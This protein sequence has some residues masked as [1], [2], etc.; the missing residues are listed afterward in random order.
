MN[1]LETQLVQNSSLL[2]PQEILPEEQLLEEMESYEQIARDV[3]EFYNRHPSQVYTS[4]PCIRFSINFNIALKDVKKIEAGG[5]PVILKYLAMRTS[6]YFRN[7]KRF[8]DMFVSVDLDEGSY[9]FRDGK[10]YESLIK[11]RY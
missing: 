2:K 1:N 4:P 10:F 5:F 11:V 3:V 8:P 9:V 6:D 7:S